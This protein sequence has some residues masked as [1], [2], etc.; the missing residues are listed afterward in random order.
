M[1]E[2]TNKYSADDIAKLSDE[3][4]KIFENLHGLECV[5]A[6]RNDFNG[7]KKEFDKNILFENILKI[8]AFRQNR[9]K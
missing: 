2:G 1:F 6:S 5:F 3:F 9:K 4:V 7:L 8:K